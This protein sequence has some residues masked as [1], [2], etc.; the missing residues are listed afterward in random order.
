MLTSYPLLQFGRFKDRTATLR[1]AVFSIN[2][3]YCICMDR[4][5]RIE[6]IHW[7]HTVLWDLAQV[8][9]ILVNFIDQPMLKLTT[10]YGFHELFLKWN[11]FILLPVFLHR[12]YFPPCL[13][14]SNDIADTRSK[15]SVWELIWIL[16]CKSVAALISAQGLI[17]MGPIQPYYLYKRVFITV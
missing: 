1:L 3:Y 4:H 10:Q 5:I 12:N 6:I 17:L 9:R 2:M 11:T 14:F 16:R 7:R 15:G 13:F 8:D